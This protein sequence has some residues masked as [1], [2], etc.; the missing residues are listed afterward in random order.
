MIVKVTSAPSRWGLYFRSSGIALT[1]RKQSPNDLPNS[2]TGPDGQFICRAG[3]L[4]Q[5]TGLENVMA[6]RAK[7]GRCSTRILKGSGGYFS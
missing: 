7:E 3:R 2:T 6:A 1:S 4:N 5:A